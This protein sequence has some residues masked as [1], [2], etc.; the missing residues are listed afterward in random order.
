M[1][2]NIS[3]QQNI[4]KTLKAIVILVLFLCSSH[5]I[6]AQI[7]YLYDATG[8]SKEEK[9]ICMNLAGI[10][11]RESAKLYVKNVFPCYSF[12]QADEKWIEEFKKDGTSFEQINDLKSLLQ[13]FDYAINGA[14]TYDPKATMGNFSG[15]NF[16]WQ[17]EFA[18]MLGGLTNRIAVSP[19]MASFLDLNVS[20]SSVIEGTNCK[21]VSRL[22]LEAHDWNDS[23]LSTD[24]RY[25]KLL[26][27]GLAHVLPHCSSKGFFIREINDFAI[28]KKLFQ[29][30]LAGTD[31]LKFTS[32]PDWKAEIIEDLLKYMRDE[33]GN[34]IFH[35]YGWM[36]PEPL[37]QWISG[38][39]AGFHE[40]MVGNLSFHHS[41][42]T[43]SPLPERKTE[44]TNT[45][46]EDKH[47]V[48]IMGTEGD[49]ANWNIGFQ[50]G[51]WLSPDRGN[52]PLAWG[53]NLHLLDLFPFI[54]NY[55]YGSATENDGFVSVMS[56]LGYVYPDMW[57][58]AILDS[59]ISKSKHSLEKFDISTLYGYKHYN[60]AGSSD[61][62]GVTINN[63]FDIFKLA[64]FNAQIGAELCFTFEPGLSTQKTYFFEDSTAIFNHVND[65]TFYADMSNITNQASELAAKLKTRKTPSFT[66]L[67]QRYRQDDFIGRNGPSNADMTMK[68]V[69]TF[70]TALQQHPDAEQK[71]QFILPEEF[72]QLI[73]QKLPQAPKPQ[74]LSNL[75]LENQNLIYP[76]HTSQQF[77]LNIDEKS[78]IEIQILDINSKIV[79][80]PKDWKQGVNVSQLKSGIYFVA[81]SN[82]ETGK[83]V[84]KKLVVR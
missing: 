74:P 48:M 19:A 46:I 43:K 66:I 37:V 52:T 21:V 62:R 33:N 32:L 81:I 40:L 73:R 59:A 47:Y 18:A 29:V 41:Y 64:K 60:G 10:V 61:F 78:K 71:V 35:V 6:S 15:Q 80:T 20:D 84:M 75:D 77:F 3:S 4:L 7:T 68:M 27:Y 23:Q 57:A 34:D 58:D 12:P 83:M 51:A 22:E 25:E 5:Q 1:Q 26:Q 36:H 44:N 39:G 14:I 63:S 17:G 50:S 79:L 70:A 9:L 49:A 69:E 11:N 42:Q 72:N 13:V 53:F 67:Y 82:G 56:P 76:N 8:K 65:N 55:Y 38:Y 2:V 24:Q 54:A 31:A 30:N 45:T 28:S 16:L